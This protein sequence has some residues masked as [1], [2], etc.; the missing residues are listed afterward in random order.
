MRE[1]VKNAL[2]IGVMRFWCVARAIMLLLYMGAIA[3]G[4]LPMWIVLDAAIG[5]AATV[6]M[7]AMLAD[8][9]ETAEKEREAR[10]IMRRKN[11]DKRFRDG[12]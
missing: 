4:E 8:K 6:A 9:I 7:A 2:I 10:R 1:R 11:W 5:C 12:A 3:E